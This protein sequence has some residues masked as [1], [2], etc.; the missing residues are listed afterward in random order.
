MLLK[1][2]AVEGGSLD[3]AINKALN[4]IRIYRDITSG[5]NWTVPATSYSS[6][7]DMEPIANLYNVV[8][9]DSYARAL[10]Y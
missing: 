3:K 1:K 2:D 5:N 7:E 9:K 4:F 10:K 8:P 6:I